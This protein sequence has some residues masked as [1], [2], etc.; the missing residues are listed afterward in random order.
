MV[1]T[2]PQKG[3][4]AT[5]LHMSIDQ[6]AEAAPIRLLG[7]NYHPQIQPMAPSSGKKK[8]LMETV[9]F[10]LLAEH[11]QSV[12]SHPPSSLPQPIKR[13]EYAHNAI[14][15]LGGINQ[16]KSSKPHTF[17]KDGLGTRVENPIDEA[18]LIVLFRCAVVESWH[19][20]NSLYCTQFLIG[21][22]ECSR[23]KNGVVCLQGT[24]M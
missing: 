16:Q 1:G 22:L 7:A 12:R 8:S 2:L 18:S 3:S 10:T 14:E 20:R 13:C 11:A 15:S 19:C 6:S 21:G 23:D 9:T 5:A 4:H 24:L 17:S